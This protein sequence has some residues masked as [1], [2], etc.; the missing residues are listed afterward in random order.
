MNN[1]SLIYVGKIVI[2][3]NTYEV[4]EDEI[5]NLINLFYK[6]TSLNDIECWGLQM[7]DIDKTKGQTLLLKTKHHWERIIQQSEK[8]LDFLN[9]K[10]FIQ[11]FPT[12]FWQDVIIPLK[13]G[14]QCNF[15]LEVIEVKKD[16]N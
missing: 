13:N 11:T 8:M 7:A 10:P 4:F 9:L 6:N 15:R 12:D 2:R 5:N 1:A 14:E 16:E 3:K